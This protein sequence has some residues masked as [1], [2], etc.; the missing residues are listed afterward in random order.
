[1]GEE[2]RI[3]TYIETEKLRDDR[4]FEGINNRFKQKIAEIQMMKEMLEINTENLKLLA[5]REFE[6]GNVLTVNGGFFSKETE[7]VH[8]LDCYNWTEVHSVVITRKE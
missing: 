8:I 5:V 2:N 6:K 1:M 4:G 7:T 3:E